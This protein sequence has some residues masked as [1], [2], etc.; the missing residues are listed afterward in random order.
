MARKRVIYQS[1]ALL[2]SRTGLTGE[3]QHWLV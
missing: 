1:E 3:R 2:V